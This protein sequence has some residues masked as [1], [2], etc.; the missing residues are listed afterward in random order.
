MGLSHEI[1]GSNAAALGQHMIGKHR[2]VA[3][4]VPVAFVIVPVLI[5]PAATTLN[6]KNFVGCHQGRHVGGSHITVIIRPRVGGSHHTLA[7]GNSP[8]GICR[9]QQ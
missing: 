4:N 3:G 1:S 6:I 2:H 5:G 9:P 8:L 7:A